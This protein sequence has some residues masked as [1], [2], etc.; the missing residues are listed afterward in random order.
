M[1]VPFLVHLLLLFA[2][3]ATAS[4]AWL[5]NYRDPGF[6]TATESALAHVERELAAA[7]PAVRARAARAYLTACRHELEFFDQALRLEPGEYGGR[8]EA[9]VQPRV[10]AP[11]A[12]SAE[13]PAAAL[14]GSIR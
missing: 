5:D 6:V 4:A 11:A 2:A 12:I 3:A 1:A 10:Q 13:A 7:S 9:P 8:A 14:A